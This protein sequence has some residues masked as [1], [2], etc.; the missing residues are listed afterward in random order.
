[1]LYRPPMFR[2]VPLLGQDAPP[3]PVVAPA[4]G[5]EVPIWPA[6]QSRYVLPVQEQ[7]VPAAP[8]QPAGMSPLVWVGI[9][10]V[11]VLA[12]VSLAR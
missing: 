5:I 2:Q 1:M 8:A 7:P 11:G 9:A 3:A 12:I 10:A 6:F 4:P